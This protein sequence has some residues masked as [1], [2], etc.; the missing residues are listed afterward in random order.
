MFPRKLSGFGAAVALS[1][2]VFASIRG[3]FLRSLRSFAA[4]PALREIFL[5][6]RFAPFVPSAF[7]KRLD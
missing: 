7:A 4:I 1:S 3:I 6:L 2:R 5:R